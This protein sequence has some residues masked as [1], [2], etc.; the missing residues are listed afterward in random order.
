[1]DG[2]WP[3]VQCVVCWMHHVCAEPGASG[4]SCGGYDPSPSGHSNGH[5]AAV[6]TL[7]LQTLFV[8]VLVKLCKSK[9]VNLVISLS[10]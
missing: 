2:P 4:N 5:N 9:H 8:L 7:A 3:Q 6:E 10:V 1:M